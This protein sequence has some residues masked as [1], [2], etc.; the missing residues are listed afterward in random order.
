MLAHIYAYTLGGGTRAALSATVLSTT[1]KQRFWHGVSL[2]GWLLI[3]IN[4]AKKTSKDGPDVRPDWMFDQISGS[5][6]LD[7][8]TTL[9]K[10]KG[11]EYALKTMR[12]HWEHFISDE[13]L[14]RA[15]A[16][17][18]DAV[19][20][21]VGYWIVDAPAT[22][23]S[24]LD[25]GFSPEGFATGGLNHLHQMLP[26]LRDRGMVAIIDM[27]ALPCNSACVS[28]GMDCAEPLAWSGQGSSSPAPIKDI[29]RCGGAGVYP[30]TRKPE[31][32][33]QSWSDVGVA[34]LGKLAKW[35]ASLPEEDKNVVAGLQLGNEPALNSPGYDQAVK[36]YYRAAIS[37]ARASLPSPMP[38][39]MSFIPPNDYDVPAF[40]EDMSNAYSSP[41]LIDHH[42]YLNWATYEGNTLAWGD[43]HAR[44]CH[45]ARNSWSAYAQAGVSLVLG[46]WSLA[47]NH[48][49]PID[50]SNQT[51]RAELAR[52]FDE[53]LEVYSTD[54]A[55]V[56][57]FY[58]TLRMGS[59]WDP[60]PTEASPNGR[61][62]EGTS[63][64]KSVP[65]FPF[66]VWSLLEMAENGIITSV[67]HADGG[68]DGKR[69]LACT[70]SAD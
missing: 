64:S 1:P 8:V 59:G 3:E 57:H 21:P 49:A 25:Y 47:T 54:K 24:N 44:A 35:I 17:A 50:L 39:L 4:K 27:H 19:R 34:N 62:I 61:Q 43:M 23:G 9:R 36:A 12:N 66:K 32:D 5:S 30:T 15:K 65:G 42:W 40:I 10:E 26:K 58:W 60:R 38:L 6:E 68:L 18:V 20:I 28:D 55:V 41:L 29:E 33:V 48:D 51:I 14:D 11:D 63:A 46:E 67:Q 70:R 31:G 69:V 45:E 52:L 22:G 2:G 16:L 37:E 56:G 7:F 13:A 53:Q